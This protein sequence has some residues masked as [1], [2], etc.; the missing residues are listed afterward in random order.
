MNGAALLCQGKTRVSLREMRSLASRFVAMRLSHSGSGL[1]RQSNGHRS[2]LHGESFR[3]REDPCKAQASSLPVNEGDLVQVDCVSLAAGGGEGIG[4]TAGGFVV[5]VRRALPGERLIAKITKCKKQYA[6][7]IKWQTMI[8]SLKE[9][10]APC[11]HFE[12]GCGGCSFQQLHYAAQLDAKRQW[13]LDHME[14]IG[15]FKNIDN[16]MKPIVECRPDIFRYRNR[17]EF[18]FQTVTDNGVDSS[19]DARKDDG[20]SGRSGFQVG[21]HL[22]G[23]SREVLEL[24]SCW[25]QSSMADKMLA[26]AVQLCRESPNFRVWYPMGGNR[27]S[28]RKR[29]RQG[30][31]RESSTGLQHLSIRRSVARD[32]YL[33]NFISAH[34]A[35]AELAPIAQQL[36]HEFNPKLIGVV[37][38]ISAHSRPIESRYI[39]EE[40]LLYGRKVLIER[41]GNIEL[42]ISANAFY[43]TNTVMAEVLY[44]A[45]T[46]AA[47]LKDEDSILDLYCGA[48]SI[49]LTLARH[50]RRALGVEIVPSAVEDARRNALRN[51]LDGKA[52]FICGNVSASL[53]EIHEV[54][55]N[56]DV[57]VVDPARPGLD[58]DVI[59]YLRSSCP[60]KAMIYV[61]CNSST[62]ARDLKSLCSK[63]CGH[64]DEYG[65]FNL[66]SIQGF[67]L[68]PHT[69]HVE[70][71]AILHR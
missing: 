52:T 42:E 55:P 26:R 56:P 54:M 19:S 49:T 61:S 5:F 60:A 28:G 41:A 63:D 50:C 40:N 39:E 7:G 20:A 59:K 23:N 65:A 70:S 11:P 8:P 24:N 68:F 1:R 29:A 51:G 9:V 4:K 64:S 47:A 35:S 27:S 33:M 30:N 22:P 13:L 32:E 53:T 37:N 15:G 43:Q 57:V 71:L 38:S 34:N 12:R 48:G 6:V 31:S 58:A 3:L 18:S 46:D 45:I 69:H 17:M 44:Q 25:L 62:Q 16:L 21:L 2:A 67:D 36:A 14:R 10:S 66:I